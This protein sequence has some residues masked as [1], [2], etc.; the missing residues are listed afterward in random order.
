MKVLIKQGNLVDVR[1]RQW[2]AGPLGR[3]QLT[4][5]MVKEAQCTHMYCMYMEMVK[6]N[7]NDPHS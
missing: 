5:E 1:R 6:D 2:L 4:S 3:T 7:I